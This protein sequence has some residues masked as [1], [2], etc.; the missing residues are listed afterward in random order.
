MKKIVIVLGLGIALIGCSKE[1]DLP[2]PVITPVVEPCDCT[3]YV[4]QWTSLE[5]N[6]EIVEETAWYQTCE[7]EDFEEVREDFMGYLTLT[8]IYVTC[9]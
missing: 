5:P 2:T 9:K 3:R 6:W 8:H 4:E 7:D 1:K